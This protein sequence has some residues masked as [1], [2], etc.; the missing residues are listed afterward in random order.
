MRD[1]LISYSAPTVALLGFKEG[2]LTYDIYS[3]YYF[4][5]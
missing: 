4:D 3:G 5:S 1:P 2:M